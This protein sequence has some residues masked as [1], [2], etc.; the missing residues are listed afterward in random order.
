MAMHNIFPH[1]PNHD[2]NMRS[3]FSKDDDPKGGKYHWFRMVYPEKT[4]DD[5]FH[6]IDSKV[7]DCCASKHEGTKH[8]D[9]NNIVCDRCKDII[10]NIIDLEHVTQIR[11]YL[12]GKK[13]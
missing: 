5:F 8:W 7:C 12:K 9:G 13:K 6:W 4:D 11:D 10:N 1:N 3:I 2:K